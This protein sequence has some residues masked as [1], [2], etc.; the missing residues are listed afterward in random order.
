MPDGSEK[1]EESFS[2]FFA[3]KKPTVF[4]VAALRG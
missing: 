1:R 4:Y 3:K 2:Q